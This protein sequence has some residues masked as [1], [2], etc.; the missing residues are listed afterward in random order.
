MEDNVLKQCCRLACWF[1][2]DEVC[3]L[4]HFELTGVGGSVLLTESLHFFTLRAGEA[5]HTNSAAT[6]H[7]AQVVLHGQ[8]CVPEET[9]GDRKRHFN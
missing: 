4:V 7:G 1:T 6:Q 5:G 8:V 2:N 9:E 3:T